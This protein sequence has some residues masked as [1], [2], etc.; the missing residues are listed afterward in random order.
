MV[1]I[2]SHTVLWCLILSSAPPAQDSSEFSCEATGVQ[3]HWPSPRVD[4]EYMHVWLSCRAATRKFQKSQNKTQK[5]IRGKVKFSIHRTWAVGSL[6]ANAQTA[7]VALAQTTV[8][9]I[10][11]KVRTGGGEEI[12]LVQGKEG[13]R[14]FAGAAMKRYPTSK[15][16]ETQVR[17]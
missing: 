5:P 14:H 10:R 7:E 8:I 2:I 11:F 3:G 16:R 12:P 4:W 17:W 15:V 6:S 13:Q 9:H 1:C